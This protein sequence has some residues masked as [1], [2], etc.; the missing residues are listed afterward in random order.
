MVMTLPLIR[1]SRTGEGGVRN[2]MRITGLETQSTMRPDSGWLDVFVTEFT[3][4]GF[5]SC[6]IL[7]STG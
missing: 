1:A 2:I 5:L 4:Y 7:T 6:R 3:W